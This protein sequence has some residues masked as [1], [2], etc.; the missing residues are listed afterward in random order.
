[1]IPL[2]RI[3]SCDPIP[4]IGDHESVLIESLLMA[5]Y[6]PPAQLTYNIFVV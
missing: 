2:P 5:K 6:I 3:R 1:M 4:S